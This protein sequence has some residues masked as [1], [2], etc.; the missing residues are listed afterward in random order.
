[1]QKIIKYAN[2]FLERHPVADFLFECAGSVLFLLAVFFVFGLILGG[3]CMFWDNFGM[4]Y[5]CLSAL[6]TSAY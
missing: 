6:S 5:M 3:W 2:N 1:M 4:E